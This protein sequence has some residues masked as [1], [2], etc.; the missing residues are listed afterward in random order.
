MASR[1]QATG[2][3]AGAAG[4]VKRQVWLSGRSLEGASSDPD[5]LAVACQLRDGPADADRSDDFI[6][7]PVNT[8]DPSVGE[9]DPRVRSGDGDGRRSAPDVDRC[10]DCVGA[11]VDAPYLAFPRRPRADGVS[12]GCD[13]I[14]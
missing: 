10:A 5:G 14:G 12:A 1:T 6:S 7:R 13:D 9:P 8:N 3:W 2:L 11:R 4:S